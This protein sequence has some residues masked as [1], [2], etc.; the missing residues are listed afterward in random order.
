MKHTDL[1]VFSSLFFLIHWKC[2][3]SLSSLLSIYEAEK[4]IGRKKPNNNKTT[5]NN[6][7]FFL[8]VSTLVLLLTI[9]NS[10][11]HPWSSCGVYLLGELQKPSGMHCCGQGRV[12][13]SHTPTLQQPLE[14]L[15]WEGCV[16]SSL[17]TLA[18]GTQLSYREQ[19]IC[20]QNPAREDDQSSTGYFSES[21]STLHQEAQVLLKA[22]V[23]ISRRLLQNHRVTQV[24]RDLGIS[25]I[26]TAAQSR[27]S[28]GVRQCRTGL[29]PAGYWKLPRTDV[30]QPPWTSITVLD[31]PYCGEVSLYIQFDPILF[32]LMLVVSHPFAMPHCEEPG[33]IFLTASSWVEEGC[34]STLGL[35]QS[36]FF[37]QTEQPHFPKPVLMEHC[38]SLSHPDSHQMNMFSFV[39]VLVFMLGPKTRC[40]IYIRLSKCWLHEWVIPWGH[41]ISLL[42]KVSPEPK[43]MNTERD[44]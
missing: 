32:Q 29:Y 23:S 36:L 41:G 34:S 43:T 14:F 16:I 22:D 17:N 38:S 18:V 20:A 35:C 15:R 19:V 27:G 2:S 7:F 44:Y 5:T 42:G 9:V 1:K 3:W 25:V 39:N 37:L 31:C 6:L 21:W 11:L 30:A 24:G 33:S 40:I 10:V 4:K 13:C 12:C 26:Q 28:S 8:L